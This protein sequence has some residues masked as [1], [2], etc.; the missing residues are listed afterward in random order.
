MSVTL[1]VRKLSRDILGKK[2]WI[3]VEPSEKKRAEY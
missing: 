2:S 1:H 3:F